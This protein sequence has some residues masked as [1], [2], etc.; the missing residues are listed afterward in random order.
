VVPKLPL[1]YV[2]Y[3]FGVSGCVEVVFVNI[4]SMLF[5]LVLIFPCYV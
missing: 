3:V 1:F 2:L 5:L 4:F